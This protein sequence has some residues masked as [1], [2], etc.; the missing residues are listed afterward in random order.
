[1]TLNVDG[2]QKFTFSMPM[3]LYTNEDEL[4]YFYHDFL[5]TNIIDN[6]ELSIHLR[7]N[8]SWY[9]ESIKNKL[10]EFAKW[11]KIDMGKLITGMRKI[12]VIFNKK[13]IDEGVFEFVIT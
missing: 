5:N 13:D 7:E 12:K 10:P 4:K 1:M 8:P 2:T 6:S 9:S 3:Y 11:E